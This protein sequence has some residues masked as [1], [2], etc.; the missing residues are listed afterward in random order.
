MSMRGPKEHFLNC[1]IFPIFDDSGNTVSF[2]GHDI[3]D[4]SGFKHRYLKGKHQGIFNRKAS[5][6]YDE[7]ILTE[8]IIDCLSLIE[9]GFENVQ[10][11]YGTNGFTGEHLQ[12]LKADR[13]K[14]VIL[15]L[16]NDEAGTFA[17]EKLK[18][19]LINEGFKVKIVSPFGPSTG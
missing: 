17:G 19:S 1:V 18:E 6:V 13:V 15:A 16:D 3:D 11:I 5:K 2:Y 8:S 14:T 7:I 4:A 9:T 10:P 12:T